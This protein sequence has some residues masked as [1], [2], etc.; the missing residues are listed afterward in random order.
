LRKATAIA[1]KVK[2][3]KYS[4]KIARALRIKNASEH[5][6]QEDI[7][8]RAMGASNALK[9]AFDFDYATAEGAKVGTTNSLMKVNRKLT[10]TLL[11]PLSKVD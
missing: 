5:F 7:F 6:M 3:D 2:K 4:G 10:D 1:L 9:V 8:A 11:I